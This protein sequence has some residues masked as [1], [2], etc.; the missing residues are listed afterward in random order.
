MIC[1]SKEDLC[2]Q[3][4]LLATRSAS[5]IAL[6]FGAPPVFVPRRGFH[7]FPYVLEQDPGSLKHVEARRDAP[8]SAVIADKGTIVLVLNLRSGK[9]NGQKDLFLDERPSRYA[10]CVIKDDTRQ[11]GDGPQVG[12]I[13]FPGENTTSIK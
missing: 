3:I 9:K 13:L 1:S 11:V 4:I 10:S 6:D 12:G 5:V 8:V 2:C 7:V